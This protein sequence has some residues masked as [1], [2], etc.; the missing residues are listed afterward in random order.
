M[1]QLK[2]YEYY[3]DESGVIYHGDY[4]Q[5]L[6]MIEEKE[7]L[8]YTD[9]PY[10]ISASGGGFYNKTKRKYIENIKNNIGVDF[11][12]NSFLDYIKD[13]FNNIYIWSSKDLIYSY[14]E[15]AIKNKYNYNLLTWNKIN[16][17]PINNNTYL[18]DTEYCIFLRKGKTYFNMNLPMN[19]YK[20][21]ILT[22][23]GK[24]NY[25][26]PT[27]KPEK[28]IVNHIKISAPEGGIVID[29]FFGSGTT[30][31]VCKKIGRRWIGIEILEKYCEIAKQRI[32]DDPDKLKLL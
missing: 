14:F 30:G 22:A 31:A 2:D 16:P 15:F 28:V 18:P 7:V 19:C 9:P 29:P 6:P 13:K 23:V 26:H 12:P 11:D 17:V 8:L 32:K 5:I 3:R 10:K 20:K 24:N 27:E 1:K 4:L 21:Y 25:G